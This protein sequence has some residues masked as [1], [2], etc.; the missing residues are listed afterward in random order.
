LA[1]K[2]IYWD[3]CAWIAL[4]NE[5]ATRVRGCRHIIQE[6]ESKNVHIIT[7]A[8]TL[9][10][11]F[12]AKCEGENKELPPE[13]DIKFEAYLDAEYVDIIQADR[14]VGT[15]ARRLL[16]KYRPNGLR[17]P[18]DAIHLATALVNDADELHTYDGSDLLGLD[19]MI[20]C[21]SGKVL[22]ILM[23]VAPEATGPLFERSNRDADDADESA[24]G[25]TT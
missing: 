9:A 4:I 16:R 10:E 2:R 11:V 6:A 23:P 20:K 18:Q 21:R 12:R 22:R 24:S 14:D 17:K 1:T 13:S 25:A 7:S 8:L 3:A 15:N 19:G 5:E